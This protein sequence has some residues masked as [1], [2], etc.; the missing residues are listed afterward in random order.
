M[1]FDSQSSPW[2]LHRD[3]HGV[4][5]QSSDFEDPIPV[6]TPRGSKLES[7][8]FRKGTLPRITLFNPEAGFEPH[9][10]TFPGSEKKQKEDEVE[11][12]E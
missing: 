1:K 9:V 2:L 7:L 12:N 6:E 4:W 10:V 3:V 8:F 5:I 11:D